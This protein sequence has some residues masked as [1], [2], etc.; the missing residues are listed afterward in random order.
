MSDLFN[1]ERHYNK[2]DR[3]DFAQAER[4]I[5][6]LN[7]KIVFADVSVMTNIFQ[8]NLPASNDAVGICAISGLQSRSLDA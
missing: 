2:I 3:L 1:L 7:Y 8:S 4:S 5:K 6:V